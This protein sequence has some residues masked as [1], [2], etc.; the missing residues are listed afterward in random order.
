MDKLDTLRRI[1]E[2]YT[3]HG[4]ICLDKTAMISALLMD[5]F[6]VQVVKL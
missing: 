2:C 6:F 3:I 1:T 5:Y 4:T